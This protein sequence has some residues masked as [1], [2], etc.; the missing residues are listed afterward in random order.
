MGSDLQDLVNATSLHP[1]GA[2]VLMADGS[3]K[4]LKSSIARNI[5]W[6]LGTRDGGEVISSDAY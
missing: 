2:N 6:A 1:G 3:A 5:W 4:F